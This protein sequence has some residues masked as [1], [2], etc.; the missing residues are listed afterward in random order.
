MCNEEL[1]KHLDDLAKEVFQVSA[2]FRS[3]IWSKFY[4]SNTALQNLTTLFSY[5]VLLGEYLDAHTFIG[6]CHFYTVCALWWCTT[7]AWQV[8][9][10]VATPNALDFSYCLVFSVYMYVLWSCCLCFRGPCQHVPVAVVP[11]FGC[12]C[13]IWLPS[14]Q[15]NRQKTKYVWYACS[16]CGVQSNLVIAILSQPSLSQ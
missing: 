7:C 15:S 5:Y 12:R 13:R 9:S 16:V 1:L 2:G 6:L 14:A 8:L 10:L 3:L 11:M 4:V